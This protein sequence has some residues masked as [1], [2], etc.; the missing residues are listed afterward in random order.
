[1][2]AMGP[3]NIFN[4][5]RLLYKLLKP[6]YSYLKHSHQ[7]RLGDSH[8]VPVTAVHYIDNS[9]SVRVVAAPVRPETERDARRTFG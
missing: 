4:Y 1:M 8:P 5:G 2:R 7:F 9:I 6:H 3:V